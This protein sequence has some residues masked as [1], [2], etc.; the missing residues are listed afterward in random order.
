MATTTLKLNC[1]KVKKFYNAQGLE[2]KGDEKKLRYNALTVKHLQYVSCRQ[3][4]YRLEILTFCSFYLRSKLPRLVY[5][6]IKEWHNGATGDCT[7]KVMI[8]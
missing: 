7:I 8:Q 5:C 3:K 1:S 4:I 6:R 2:I